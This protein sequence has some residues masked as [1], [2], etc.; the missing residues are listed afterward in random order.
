MQ[1]AHH[2]RMVG[3]GIVADRD[4]QLGL[5]K[6]IEGDRPFTDADGLRQANAGRLV[7][8]IGAVRKVVGAVFAGK[9]LEQE[10]HFVR[11]APGGI[12]LDFI[13]LQR[14]ENGAD[15]GKRRFP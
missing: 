3:S 7:A 4:N 13:R 15:A 12:K 6:V 2:A 1:R 10:G 11:G 9:Q 5:I 8:H 14:T